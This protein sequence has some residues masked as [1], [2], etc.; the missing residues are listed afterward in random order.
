MDTKLIHNEM[1][2]EIIRIT[3]VANRLGDLKCMTY[4]QRLDLRNLLQTAVRHMQVALN[5]LTPYQHD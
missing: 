4:E 5:D 1:T 3:N 2:T